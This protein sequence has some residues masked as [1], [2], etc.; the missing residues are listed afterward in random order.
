MNHPIAKKIA[1]LMS[2]F[3]SVCL[4]AAPTSLTTL[5]STTNNVGGYV[6]NHGG[7]DVMTSNFNG[8][9]QVFKPFRNFTGTAEQYVA[10]NSFQF[11]LGSDYTPKF[12]YLT[13][14]PS[15][16]VEPDSRG[17][18]FI[19]YPNSNYSDY[20]VLAAPI[21]AGKDVDCKAQT[22]TTPGINKSSVLVVSVSS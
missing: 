17:C 22:S 7:E 12:I 18:V 13:T 19:F 3:I 10:A 9:Q 11:S 20:Y 14:K 21:G 6:I 16:Q 4:F 5:S 2:L 8:V 1:F 15:K